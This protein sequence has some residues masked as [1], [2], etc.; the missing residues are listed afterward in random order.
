MGNGVFRTEMGI[1]NKEQM[2]EFN[3]IQDNI[4]DVEPGVIEE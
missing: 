3:F 4:T 2:L 1:S